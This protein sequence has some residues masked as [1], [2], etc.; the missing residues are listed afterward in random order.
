MPFVWTC[1]KLSASWLQKVATKARIP[2]FDSL[3]PKKDK[4]TNI[5]KKCQI[6]G[7][8]FAQ[9]HPKHPKKRSSL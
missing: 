1:E 9:N 4:K 5:P 3:N 8:K 2:N 7:A 6:V